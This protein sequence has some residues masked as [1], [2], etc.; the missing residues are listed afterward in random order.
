[1][2]RH[3]ITSIAVIVA[4]ASCW[5]NET[6]TDA[7]SV[8]VTPVAFDPNGSVE[9]TTDF[10]L[11]G[12]GAQVEVYASTVSI[13]R[14]ENAADTFALSFPLGRARCRRRPQVEAKPELP[15]S[16]RR[17]TRSCRAT[18]GQKES[19]EGFVSLSGHFDDGF[20][21]LD[22]RGL[23]D[24]ENGRSVRRG[25]LPFSPY[26]LVKRVSSAQVVVTSPT[27]TSAVAIRSRL[28][29]RA[30]PAKLAGLETHHIGGQ[31]ADGQPTSYIA[32]AMAE[33]R[34]VR[35]LDRRGT[36]AASV[37][38]DV[39][40]VAGDE[41]AT[42]VSVAGSDV[43]I[44][45]IELLTSAMGEVE[46]KLVRLDGWA[47]VTVISAASTTEKDGDMS[48]RQTNLLIEIDSTRSPMVGGDPWPGRAYA[49]VDVTNLETA[50]PAATVRQVLYTS[51][52]KFQTEWFTHDR[53]AALLIAA[54]NRLGIATVADGLCWL[55]GVED[56]E[57]EQAVGS[58][59][60][61]ILLSGQHMGAPVTVLAQDVK[62]E[63]RT[64]DTIS[65]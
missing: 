12:N 51:G 20:V 58:P 3:S 34:V 23:S 59:T 43:R 42:L 10:L 52:A 37:P 61:S 64:L 13:S 19:F 22:R 25:P 55:T 28:D 5:V 27:S 24:F 31:A 57:V 2:R 41:H 29:L 49:W 62:Y 4:S 53:R 17:A 45:D 44:D 32:E 63:N 11:V 46:P 30:Y 65:R 1:M 56:I 9:S 6:A 21:I 35:R 38:H 39:R 54:E 7:C 14:A 26:Q 8:D 16:F 60:G 15:F 33:R 36:D 50:S 48:R 47:L 40:F 18:L